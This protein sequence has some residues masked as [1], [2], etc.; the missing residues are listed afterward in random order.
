MSF[1]QDIIDLHMIA[2]KIENQIGVGK[3]SQDLRNVADRL[4]ELTRVE[5]VQSTT[6]TD[7]H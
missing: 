7:N 5:Y 3:L 6:T 4:H 2:G 1:N